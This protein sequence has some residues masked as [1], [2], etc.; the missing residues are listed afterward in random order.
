MLLNL[1]SL[2]AAAFSASTEETRYYLKVTQNTV[3]YVATNGHMM[4]AI[5]GANEGGADYAL[6][7]PTEVID[8]FKVPARVLNQ[9]DPIPCEL[10]L[11]EDGFWE[12]RFGDQRVAFKDLCEFATYPDWRRVTPSET[13]GKAA[14]YNPDYLVA[15]KK[16]ARIL[17][18]DKNPFVSVA[19]N[20][21]GPALVFLSD[22]AFGVLMPIRG[23][24]ERTTPPAWFFER[25]AVAA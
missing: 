4:L 2:K 3:T 12:L 15:F 7:I 17:T 23:N 10:S 25:E 21:L 16:A 14:N 13:N 18:G 1:R 22:K 6:T 9:G 24:N 5:R 19:H 20:G 8:A 11:R